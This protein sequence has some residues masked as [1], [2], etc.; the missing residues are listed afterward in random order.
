MLVSRPRYW[1]KAQHFHG[2]DTPEAQSKASVLYGHAANAFLNVQ[3]LRAEKEARR[4]QKLTADDVM[5][6]A[7]KKSQ[8]LEIMDRF[9]DSIEIYEW[10]TAWLEFW[11][12]SLLF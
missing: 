11:S 6:L 1:K 2:Q 10:L 9:D 12:S 4:L 8:S 7:V 5:V 3:E